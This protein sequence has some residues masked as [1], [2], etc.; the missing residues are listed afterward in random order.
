[1]DALARAA[2]L[3]NLLLPPMSTQKE[4]ALVRT[5]SFLLEKTSFQQAPGIQKG[6][7]KLTPSEKVLENL[8]MC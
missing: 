4:F 6:K 3:A 7:Q 2:T 1:M 8:R 5:N